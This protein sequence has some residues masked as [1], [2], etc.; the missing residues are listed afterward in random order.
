MPTIK[1]P[2]I[3]RIISAVYKEVLVDR[4]RDQHFWILFGFIPTFI[5]ARIL[6]KNDPRIFL[7]INGTHVHHFAYGFVIL[8]IAGYLANVRPR[9]SPPWLAT[10]FGIGLALAVDEAGMW[11]H[12][13]DQYYNET[14]EYVI[15]AVIILLINVTYLREFWI[16]IFKDIF[17][18]FRHF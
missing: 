15:I 17:N 14:S 8:A 12:L 4:Y 5:I 10:L 16:R 11:L 6:V 2:R 1:K 3:Y 18:L 9:R 13:T 7:S